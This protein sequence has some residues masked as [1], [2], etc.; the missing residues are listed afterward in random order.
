MD[1]AILE[2]QLVALEGQLAVTPPGT[3]EAM[4]LQAQIVTLQNELAYEPVVPPIW[5]PHPWHGGHG[6]R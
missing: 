5:G 2:A 3:P 1:R 6:G 4:T